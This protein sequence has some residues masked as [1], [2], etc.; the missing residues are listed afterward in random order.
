MSHLPRH[1]QNNMREI[2]TERLNR[3]QRNVHLDT[4]IQSR[5]HRPQPH[6]QRQQRKEWI[7]NTMT[8]SMVVPDS[9]FLALSSK[10]QCEIAPWTEAEITSE[11]Q[12]DERERPGETVESNSDSL[13]LATEGRKARSRHVT[14]LHAIRA[15][16]PHLHRPRRRDQ[17]PPRPTGYRYNRAGQVEEQVGQGQLR[18]RASFILSSVGSKVRRRMSRMSGFCTEM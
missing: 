11:D 5:H 10:E 17:R 4:R 1:L 2:Q 13:D 14:A 6:Q 15:C 7:T 12:V 16:S 9:G 18:R 8:R 3:L